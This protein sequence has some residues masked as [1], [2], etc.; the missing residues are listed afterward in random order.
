MTEF[1]QSEVAAYYSVRVPRVVQKGREW[2]GPCPVHNGKDPNFAASSITGMATCHSQCGRSWDVVG[3]EMELTTTSFSKA[4]ESVYKIMGRPAIPYEDREIEA[5]YDYT[6]EKGSLVYQVVRKYGKKFRQRRARPEGGWLWSIEGIARLPFQLPRLIAEE[7]VGVAEGE[8]DALNLTRSGMF[9]TCNSEGAGKFHSYMAKWFSG[10]RCAVFSDNDEPGRKHALDVAATLSQVAKSVRIVELPGLPAKGDVSD[11]LS[12][13]GTVAQILNRYQ[14]AAEWTPEWQFAVEVPSEEDKH[15]RTFEQTVADCG[16]L[17]A[18]WDLTTQEGIQTPWVRLSWALGGGLRPGEVYIIGGNQG[19]GKSSLALQFLLHVISQKGAALLFSMEMPWRDVFQ[20]LVA[21]AARVD[22][23]WLRDAQRAKKRG[24]IVLDLDLKEAVHRL[25]VES[26]LQAG[27]PLLVSNRS[28]VNPEYLLAETARISKRQKL[29]LVV[30]DHMQLMSS[31][32]S[33]RTD[34]E[35]FTAISRATKQAAMEMKLPVLV[36]SQTSRTNSSEKRAEL[37]VSD[38]RS[39]G[40][41]E[42]DAAAVM[43]L[44]PD[45]EHRKELMASNQYAK[46][47]VKSWL[48][49]GKNRYGLTGLYIPMMHHKQWTRFDFGHEQER[50]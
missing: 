11:F 6:D 25:G 37:E 19:S 44:Y 36:V 29:D 1:T 23:M 47:P 20:R 46:G 43:L 48:K 13:G 41:L 14:A 18:F 49:L 27:A 38:L 30:V 22:L 42:E 15:V 26:G 34:T 40:A 5:I 32:G 33:E 39:S 16:G 17:D 8:K 7:F 10:K 35:K 31:T 50:G 28:G 21:I 12:R 45:A 9:C 2:R 3:L 24:E 4:K